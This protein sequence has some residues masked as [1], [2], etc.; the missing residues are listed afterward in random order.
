MGRTD[1]DEIVIIREDSSS[2]VISGLLLGL[3]IGAAAG[4]LRAPKSGRQLRKDLTD[5]AASAGN[6]ARSRLPSRLRGGS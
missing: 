4:L 2:G 5:R 6:S 1:N 3:A